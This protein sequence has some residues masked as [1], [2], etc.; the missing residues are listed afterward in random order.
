MLN[1]I[2][3]VRHNLIVKQIFTIVKTWKWSKYAGKF[4]C[5]YVQRQMLKKQLQ[6]IY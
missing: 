4:H 3:R 5:W 1:A 2:L 6:V